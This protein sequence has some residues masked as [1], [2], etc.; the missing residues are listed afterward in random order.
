MYF[1]GNSQII[2]SPRSSIS[3]P[4]RY[5][6][7]LTGTGARTSDVVVEGDKASMEPAGTGQVDVTFR[8]DLETFVLICFGR[9]AIDASVATDRLTIQGEQDLALEFQRWFPGMG[10]ADSRK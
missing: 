4:I 7:E 8:C 5:R 10:S 6:W 1:R 2:F 3:K 9:L